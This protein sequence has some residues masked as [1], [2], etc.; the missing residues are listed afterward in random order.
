MEEIIKKLVFKMKEAYREKH[1]RKQL[2]PNVWRGTSE[3]C[4]AEFENQMGMALGKIFGDGYEVLVAYTVTLK[5]REEDYTPTKRRKKNGELSMRKHDS[6]EPDILIYRKSDHH[7]IAIFDLK[8]DVSRTSEEWVEKA[9]KD[10][11]LYKSA[12]GITFKSKVPHTKPIELVCEKEIPYLFII[13]NGENEHKRLKPFL[14]Q[15]KESDL[16]SFVLNKKE[17]LNDIGKVTSE[18]L[19]SVENQKEWA[20]L[21]TELERIKKN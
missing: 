4:S 21:A 8:N 16:P 11:Q 6:R 14:K 19:N 5:R 15:M 7:I 12:T 9:V 2:S 3:N 18:N 17:H 1:E 20:R 13:L 10:R